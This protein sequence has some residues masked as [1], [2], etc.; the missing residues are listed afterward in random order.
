MPAFKDEEIKLGHHRNP[1][2]L[3][4]NT[5][6]LF[7]PQPIGPTS[8]IDFRLGQNK[9]RGL[10]E[11]V[12]LAHLRKRAPIKTTCQKRKAPSSKGWGFENMPAI[13]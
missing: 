12:R 4:T 5:E 10:R 2:Q 9:P 11:L 6:D 8:P 1:P 13:T 3:T 7:Y